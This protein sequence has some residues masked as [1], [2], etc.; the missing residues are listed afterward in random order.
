ML[1]A[2]A[3]FEI[4]NRLFSLSTWVYI[5]IFF[6]GA[7]LFTAT[8]AGLFS[9]S[10][11]VAG[12]AKILVNSPHNLMRNITGIGIFG[13]TIMATVMGR[14]VQT[15]F[16][17]R[18]LHFFFTSP[19][20][21]FEYLG[22]RFLGAFTVV[23]LIFASIGLGIFLATLLPGIDP[24]RVGKN[25][26]LHY[27]WPYLL[28]L[29]PNAFLIGGVF[30]MAAALTR[31]ML[32]V[33]VGSAVLLLGYLIGRTYFSEFD[34]RN[35]AAWIDPFGGTAI[36]RV[37]EYWT[38]AERNEQLVP[39]EGPLLWNR[40]FWLA[41]A[42]T[43][44]VI[45]YWRF[46]FAQFST[47]TLARSARKEAAAEKRAEAEAM[48]T[49]SNAR[50]VISPDEPNGMAML[51]RMV[52][53]NFTETI[54][55]I[56]F[57]VLVLA[58]LLLMVMI[59]LQAGRIYGTT[60][61]PLTF[62]MIESVY[63]GFALFMLVLITFYAGELTWRERDQRLDQIIDATAAP[64][65]LAFVSKLLALMMVPLILTAVLML[66]G[67]VIQI[68]NGYYRFELGLYVRG[69]FGSYLVGYWIICAIAITIHSVV[70]NK[71]LGHFL[72]I[73]FYFCSTFMGLLGF[74]HYLY[75]LGSIPT[76]PYSDMNGFG[77]YTVREHWFLAYWSAAVMLLLFVGYLFWQRGV[78]GSWR[79]RLHFARERATRPVLLGFAATSALFVAI[80]AFIFYNTNV[81]NRYDTTA[82]VEKRKADYEKSYKAFA[83]EAQP[84]VTAVKLQ[85][86]LFPQTQSVRMR[87]SYRLVNPHDAAI[88]TVHLDFLRGSNVTIDKLAFSTG[89]TL[90]KEDDELG[91]R[92]FKLTRALGPGEVTDLEFDVA[93]L[94]R[95][96]VN[97]GVATDVVRNGS[98]LNAAEVLPQIGYQ[99][100]IELV[101]DGDR[102]KFGLA[103][104]ERKRDRDDVAGH[105]ENI[106]SN[107]S[108]WVDFSAVVSTDED[109]IAIAP[110]YV[111]RE[112][113]EAGRRYV[114][115][116]SDA[117]IL[118]AFAFQ[119]ARYAVKQDRWSGPTGDVALEIYHHPTHTFNL[120]SMM[121]AS[122]A[123]LGYMTNTIGPY[124]HRQL[125][126]VEFPRY[127]PFAQ[128]FANTIPYSEGAGFISRVNA[129]DEKNID[130]PYY[131]TAHET[132]HQWWGHALTPANVQGASML[133]EALAQYSALMVMK[134][135]FG[136]ARMQKFLSYELDRYLTGR[137]LEQKKEVPLG[138]VEDQH[139]IHYSKGSLAMYALQDYIG[140]AN[141][142]RAL[143]TFYE[144]YAFKGPPYPSAT[145]LI[146]RLRE[147]TPPEYQHVIDDMFENII[148]Y[149]N[150][151]MAASFRAI[152]GGKY[153]VRLSVT[154]KKRKSDTL[155]KESDIA[156]ADWI[157]IGV[158]D[159]KGVPLFLEKRKIDKQESEFVIMVD[160]LPA[161]AGIDPFNKLIDRRPK[162]NVIGVVK[163]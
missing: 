140:E 149:E 163:G 43:A 48:Q 69:L 115:F 26:L 102:R 33:Y 37:V 34:N 63:A 143:K 99:P 81:L 151:A 27:L 64:P 17:H 139:Y 67:I 66:S 124:P 59:T 123:S 154:A 122:K 45:C 129:N 131:V 103:P 145:T 105:Q 15:D 7:L 40:L 53:I 46:G 135:R 128:A 2:I 125:R 92:R 162:D 117:P 68:V 95:G 71:Y 36:S 61:W 32:P 74:E 19:I 89:A 153:E 120:D 130:F 21:K 51:P 160:K 42:V 109:Q 24:A 90:L 146:K 152:D 113:T 159:E 29:L 73:A 60:I 9:G 54:K 10:L 58:G 142:N 161:K 84:E 141:V 14:A 38:I 77:H 112:W 148:V 98:F 82:K 62:V 5:G 76:M 31:K 56:Y 108:H 101:R 157:D 65:W 121:A 155:G 79:E 94:R 107:F 85:V 136:E 4:R 3:R 158:L 111:Q 16:E 97:E 156:I 100:A 138:R 91:V 116:K 134:A 25:H 57:G 6:I 147:V 39:L 8:D 13:L 126:I 87:G 133:S 20:T 88:D 83:T 52:W 12:S 118:N 72:M 22:G 75:R 110:G 44:I 18:T 50:L 132:A 80:G 104:K 35:L 11:G 47:D 30:F 127:R 23:A 41:V 78:A 114:E 70:N 150:R 119:S 55:N 93:L 49:L 106:A 137:A 1:S 28:I 86:D 144:D 96:F